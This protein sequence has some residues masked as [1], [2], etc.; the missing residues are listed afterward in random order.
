MVKKKASWRQI[1]V[2]QR[3]RVCNLCG[4]LVFV[5]IIQEVPELHVY[6]CYLSCIILHAPD[7]RIEFHTHVLELPNIVSPT[8]PAKLDYCIL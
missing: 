7:F 4:C 5:C 1:C 3:A 6:E 8:M 2:I